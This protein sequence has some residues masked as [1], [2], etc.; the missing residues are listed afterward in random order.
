MTGGMERSCHVFGQK[1]TLS[2]EEDRT[3][4]LHVEASQNSVAPL[5]FETPSVCTEDRIASSLRN[6]G[7]FLFDLT[8]SYLKRR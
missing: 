3:D 8:A 4:F 5:Y 2:T 1:F 6:F 7:K